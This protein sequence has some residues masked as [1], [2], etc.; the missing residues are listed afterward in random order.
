[1]RPSKPGRVADNSTNVT[2]EK[3]VWLAKPRDSEKLNERKIAEIYCLQ[4]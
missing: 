1:M 3:G 4:L 2:E